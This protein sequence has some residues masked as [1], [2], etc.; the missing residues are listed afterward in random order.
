MQVNYKF[1]IIT[2][3]LNQQGFIE[4]NL[5]SVADQQ[6]DFMVEHIVVDGHS[7]D[8][9]QDIL[10]KYSGQLRYV[11]EPDQGMADALNKGFAMATGEINGWLNSDDTYLPGTLQ[12]VAGYFDQHPDCLW[13]YGNC[14]IIDDQDREIRRWITNYKNRLAG[15]FSFKRLLVD[16]FISQPAVFIRHDALKAAGPVDIGLPTAMDYDLWLRLAKLGT[17]GYINHDLACFRVHQASI[18]SRGYRDQFEE[19]YR[20]H[21]RYDQSPWLLF[22]HRIKIRL[23]VLVYSFWEYFGLK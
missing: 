18:S 10:A 8:G 12:K 4:R 20:I 2:P 22:R 6:A 14:R 23:I 3:S 11:S 13:L 19:Q 7:T 16:N 15:K 5:R 9:T 17:P 1:S 21:K